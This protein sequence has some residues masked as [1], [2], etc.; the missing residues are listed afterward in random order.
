MDFETLGA[1]KTVWIR[2]AMTAVVVG[3]ILTLINQWEAIAAWQGV[4][5]L[6]FAMTLLVPFCVSAVTGLA[7]SRASYRGFARRQAVVDQALEK[8]NI[9]LE[10]ERHRLRELQE[11]H[12]IVCTALEEAH[13]AVV[14]PPAE[15]R[16]R[17]DAPGANRYVRQAGNQI[18]EIRNNALRVNRSSEERVQFISALIERCEGVSE[19]VGRLGVEA[20]ESGISVLEIDA[21]I[22]RIAGSVGALSD[23][24]SGTVSQVAEMTEVAKAF[25][26]KFDLV[27][28]ATTRL[29]SL[30]YQT[31]LLALNA[32]IEAARA[33][34]AGKGFNVVATEVRHLAESST[35]DSSDIAS[36]VEQLEESLNALLSRISAVDLTL[37]QNHQTSAECRSLSNEIC[38]D[39]ERLS[40]R[41]R[42]TSQ[43]TATQLP[44]VVGLVEDI[45]QI[46]ANT[47]AAVTGSANNIRL[48]EETMQDLRAALGKGRRHKAHRAA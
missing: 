15:Q 21:G 29:G 39:V 44:A 31:R 10:A 42:Y 8:G 43:E 36:F 13:A 34:E 22:G 7:V 26:E 18:I 25:Q 17:D 37:S 3:P 46:K 6:K 9:A 20:E 33:G 11:A 14:G 47:E 5:G 2:A 38:S 4:D 48:C 40:E 30:A 45:K 19:S 32:T 24:I 27:K 23:E 12:A 16:A 28:E 1:R 35:K 41:I